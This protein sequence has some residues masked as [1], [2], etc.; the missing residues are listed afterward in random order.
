[1][2]QQPAPDEITLPAYT[3]R[4]SLTTAFTQRATCRD[5]TG[6]ALSVDEVAAVL[7][8]A[9][10]GTNGHAYPS[11][12][13]RRPLT[14]RA[15][16]ASASRPLRTAYVLDAGS[17]ALR[18]QAKDVSDPLST[19]AYDEQPWLDAAPLVLSL[20]A[21]LEPMSR[22]F[23]DQDSSGLRGR[24]FVMLEAGTLAQNVLL[25]AAATGLGAVLVGGLR[26]V[27]CQDVLATDRHVCSLIAV[28]HPAT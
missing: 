27:A 2:S 23:A 13:D 26:Q 16:V 6:D 28:G 22:E 9:L 21:G 11:A 3:H 24:D 14:V 1:M 20:E 17:Q 8:G 10:R 25:A 7:S 12:H 5:F 19:I 4:A 15:L 18:R